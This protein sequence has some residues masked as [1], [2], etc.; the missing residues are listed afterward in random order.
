MFSCWIKDFRNENTKDLFAKFNNI[1]LGDYTLVLP[2]NNIFL[3]SWSK[4]LHNCIG[5]SSHYGDE[6]QNGG[7]ILY[8]L[9]KDDVVNFAIEIRNKEIV[10]FEGKYRK[11][12]SDDLLN[13]VFDK[14]VQLKLIK[15]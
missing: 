9:Y 1:P 5:N 3:K 7:N 13:K 14:L 15:G 12:P 11:K 10:Q 4:V 8:G 6:F 2:K